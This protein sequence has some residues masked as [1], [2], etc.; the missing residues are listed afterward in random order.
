LTDIVIIGAGIGGLAAAI[1]LAAAGKR[2]TV[3]EQNERTGGKMGV[4]ST[5]GF[6]WDTGPS[7][8]TMRWVFEDLF[9]RAGRRLDDYLTLLP[10]KPLT[11]YFYPDGSL[12]D[13]DEDPKLTAQRLAHFD[14]RDED[15]YLRFLRYA[16]TIHVATGDVFI[17][18][19]PPTW[20]TLFRVNPLRMLQAD[21]LRPMQRAIEGFV[22]SRQARQLLG[23]FATYTGASPYLAPATLNVIAHVEL[24]E[25]VFYPQGGIAQIAA[26][27][28]QLA[29]EMG[30]EI[31]TGCPVDAID[32]QFD[33]VT[34]VR[35]KDGDRLDANH[36]I[37]NVD[38]STV[39]ERML[40]PIPTVRR[41]L[42]RLTKLEPSSSGFILLLGVERVHEQL[43]HHNIFFSRDYEDEFSD[44]FGRGVPPREPTIYVAITSKTDADHAP[45][46]TENWFV[47]VNT[48]AEN[49]RFDWPTQAESY[50]DLVLARLATDFD[51][52]VRAHLRY[53]KT[54][55]PPELEKLSGARN[56][57][58]YGQSSND[59]MA[60]FRRP[61]NRASA[62]KGLYFAGGTT[63]PG[64]GVPMVTL[65]G[66]VAAQLVLEDMG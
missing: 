11:R 4:F 17:Y 51:L 31:R 1:H 55:T 50:R 16:N 29:Q 24:N 44:I 48:P 39:Y 2:V 21:A 40:P 28:T 42:K 38:V 64:G 63:H 26:A 62:V 57:A 36:V 37:A 66:K 65:S 25:G 59:R 46:G 10:L 30:V 14:P 45:A 13:V 7:V 52:D 61:H 43:A 34:G 47:L 18:G 22:H 32:L 20:Q 15:G 58:L 54:I 5:D 53:T 41:E 56:G 19:A 8:I 12:L 33:Q 27:L 60:A 49:G 3:V 9:R 6:R 23:R 35:L